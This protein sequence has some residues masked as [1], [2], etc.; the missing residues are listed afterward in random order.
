MWFLDKD[1]HERMIEG[2]RKGIPASGAIPMSNEGSDGDGIATFAGDTAVIRING[3]LTSSRDIFARI[4]G[5]GNTLY[6]DIIKAIN[7]AEKDDS[8]Q[9]VEFQISSGGGE[10]DGMFDVIAAMQSMKKR[11]V[12]RVKRAASAAYGIASQADSI[13]AEGKHSSVGSVGVVVTMDVPDREVTITSSLAPNKRP[14]PTTEEGRKVITEQLDA[15]HAL[16]VDAIAAGRRTS[17]AKVNEDY[18]GGKM[19]L[20]TEAMKR[21]MVDSIKDDRSTQQTP[22]AL[23]SGANI[24]VLSMDLETLKAQ[25]PAVY[26]LAFEEGATDARESAIAHLELGEACGDMSIA[27]EAIKAN[28]PINERIRS[29][30]FAASMRSAQQQARLSD[31]PDTSGLGGA[32]ASV[33]KTQEELDAEASRNIEAKLFENLGVLANG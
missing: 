11:K 6:P 21:G 30:Y 5:G 25:H 2:Y 9:K 29:K 1:T 32:S 19:F 26:R 27:V 16:F 12:A 8:I 20:A 14:D 15:Y 18:G 31:N 7:T 22:V 28:N 13:V 10:A 4:F 24:K 23:S 3:V 17:P 33:G